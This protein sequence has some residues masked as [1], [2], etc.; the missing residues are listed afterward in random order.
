MPSLIPQGLISPG[1]RCLSRDLKQPGGLCGHA[2]RQDAVCRVEIEVGG[3]RRGVEAARGRPCE[4]DAPLAPRQAPDA[5][6]LAVT[7]VDSGHHEAIGEGCEANRP[8]GQAILEPLH[9]GKVAGD[10][11]F[12]N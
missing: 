1:Q 9:D 6:V 3:Q 2:N 8:E 10:A 5:E 7:A 11:S 12:T 4:R